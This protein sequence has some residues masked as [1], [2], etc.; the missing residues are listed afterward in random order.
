M[1]Y[2]LVELDETYNDELIKLS[3]TTNTGSDLFYVDRVPNFFHLSNGFGETRQFGLFK[4]KELIG[5]VAVSMHYRLIGGIC[6]KTYYLN[7]LRIH[8]SYQKTLAFYR[9]FQ[10]LHSIYEKEGEV[11]WMF[12]TVLDG[13]QNSSSFTKDTDILP[14]GKPIG[15][16]VHIGIPL[17]IPLR[18][19][20]AEY[21][22][23]EIK[24]HEAWPIFQELSKGKNFAPC[25]K[26]LFLG[27]NDIFLTIKN[28]KNE[29]LALCK[30]VDQSAARKL[31]YSENAPL[32][33]KI[34]NLLCRL[35][36]C[37]SLPGKDEE[38]KH[39][40]MA[41]Y[42]TKDSTY[43]YRE[44]FLPYIQNQYKHRYTY[45]FFGV[46]ELHAVTWRK[47]LFHIELSS[48][49]YGYGDL[50][51]DTVINFHELTLI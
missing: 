21:D 46:S 25:D 38:F 29:P 7:D 9:M 27:E 10:Q 31:R 42:A 19:K 45:L 44:A 18:Q 51:G 11:K 13:N 20:N 4:N 36:G 48:T 40:Y 30:L 15:K 32:S 49:T 8:P 14:R 1:T 43:D 16:T 34:L 17:F 26:R 28:R 39:A 50:P 5:S 3:F 23:E 41:F 22:I 47:R 35:T 33:F 12:S 37:P 24:G 2:L 6:T